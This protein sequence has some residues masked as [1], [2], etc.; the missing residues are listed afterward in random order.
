M[1]HLS[2][3]VSDLAKSTAFYDAVL[4]ALNYRRVWTG[5]NGVGYGVEEGKDLFALKKR[6]ATVQIPS[7][8][9][10]LAFAAKS[11]EAV[12]A[13]FATAM[14][15]GATDNGG[16]GFRPQYEKHYYAAFI[17]DLDGYEIEAVINS[18]P[19]LKEPRQ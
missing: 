11:C 13:F 1:H 8:G 9:F 7:P 15:M 10:H 4:G 2:F 12:D 6:M 18:A 19:S 3:S 5:T 16:S 17:I 14:R